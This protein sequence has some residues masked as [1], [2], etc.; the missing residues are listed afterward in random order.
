MIGYLQDTTR[1]SLKTL[2]L[3]HNK[4]GDEGGKAIRGA[5]QGKD[6]NLIL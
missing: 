3:N 5:W 6:A 1:C 2:S 4:I